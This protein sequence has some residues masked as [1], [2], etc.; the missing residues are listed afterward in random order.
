MLNFLIVFRQLH[1]FDRNRTLL[2]QTTFY[3]CSLLCCISHEYEF[4]T[5]SKKY[6][7]FILLYVVFLSIPHSQAD[8]VS[9]KKPFLAT[10]PFDK[11]LVCVPEPYSALEQVLRWE[12]EY[13]RSTDIKNVE[14]VS[15]L[16]LKKHDELFQLQRECLIRKNTSG[17]TAIKP[18]TRLPDIRDA[19]W[20]KCADENAHCQFHGMRQVR[21]GKNGK[22]VFE[23]FK[24]GVLCSNEVFGDP[25]KNV[26]KEC[27]V[28]THNG[29]K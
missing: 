5:M 16:L 22:Y 8:I 20:V 29:N 21:Y 17:A 27:F 4:E 10:V 2:H 19:N 12:I 15:A 9:E 26:L 11:D 14:G 1:K 24:D 18:E 25:I 23:T 28:S 13:L 3:L 6:S 7:I